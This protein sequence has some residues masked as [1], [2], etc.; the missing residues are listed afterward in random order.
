MARVATAYV[1]IKPDMTGFTRQLREKLAAIKTTLKVKV[2]PDT[3]ALAKGIAVVGKDPKVRAASKKA[4]QDVGSGI[5]DALLRDV[6]DAFESDFPFS[7]HGMTRKGQ[8]MG[9]LLG[10]GL[11]DRADEGADRWVREFTRDLDKYLTQSVRKPLDNFKREAN[12]NMRVAAEEAAESFRRAW[13]WEFGSLAPDEDTMRELERDFGNKFGDVGASTVRRMGQSMKREWN[14]TVADAFRENRAIDKAAADAAKEMDRAM[15]EAIRQN[16]AFDKATVDKMMKAA[17]DSA[18]EYDRAWAEAIQENKE[19]DAALRRKARDSHHAWLGG[20]AQSLSA[21]SN[22]WSKMLTNRIGGPLVAGAIILAGSFVAAWVGGVV[23]ALAGIGSLGLGT[24]LA[25][26]DEG[27]ASA[28][29][30]LGKTFMEHFTVAAGV[31]VEPIKMSLGLLEA[32]MSGWAVQMRG[33]FAGLAPDINKLTLGASQAVSKLLEGVQKGLPAI[34]AVLDSLSRGM[35]IIAEA[36][37]DFFEKMS[38]D[39]DEL[40]RAM[41]SLFRAI[42]NVINFMGSTVSTLTS[43][44]VHIQMLTRNIIS[45]GKALAENIEFYASPSMWFNK[46]DQ[47]RVNSNWTN[48]WNDITG[49][50]DE[51]AQKM[52]QAEIAA[53]EM[54]DGLARSVADVATNASWTE[55]Q[56]AIDKVSAKFGGVVENSAWMRDQVVKELDKIQRQATVTNFDKFAEDAKNNFRSVDKATTDARKAVDDLIDSINVLNGRFKDMQEAEDDFSETVND[57]NEELKER[58]AILD[59][60]SQAAIDNREALRD[61]AEGIEDTFRATLKQ[62]GSLEQ[63]MAKYEA[64]KQVLR[65]VLSQFGLTGQAAEDYINKLLGTPE[66]I[67]T[68]VEA[69]GIPGV[70]EALEKLT[71]KKR[72]APITIP[73]SDTRPWMKDLVDKADWAGRQAGSATSKGYAGGVEEGKPAAAKAGQSLFGAAVQGTQSGGSLWGAGK[74]LGDSLAQGLLAAQQAA[75]GAASWI[76]STIKSFFPNSPK[77]KQGPLSGLGDLSYSGQTIAN[78]LAA[79]MVKGEDQ[80]SAAATTLANASRVGWPLADLG[81]SQWTT[82]WMVQTINVHV[83]NDQLDAYIQSTV[84]DDNEALARGLLAGRSGV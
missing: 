73:T 69:L 13:K 44:A 2:V 32:R 82:P 19:F 58:E 84:D 3:S 35:P 77:A 29:R 59:G 81:A 70:E 43:W 8:Q 17:R 15:A 7:T 55:V 47:D 31:L 16:K 40:A 4:G 34:R 28:A 64:Q 56:A 25:A 63:A 79:G 83:G 37:G 24:F 57:L 14:D 30:S 74:A 18:R 41:D 51:A 36:I 67:L 54:R 9:D 45:F 48:F 78:N 46:A 60:N 72:T 52:R 23:A 1:E 71:G 62:T 76:A 6:G 38:E 66:Q 50:T 10:E 5:S 12:L 26:Q 11:A 68:Q 39:P 53:S 61:M 22:G 27:V 21:V 20:F 42:R 33:I 65:D 75:A 80:V 49:K